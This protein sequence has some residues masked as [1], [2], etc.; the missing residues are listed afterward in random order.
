MT[1]TQEQQILLS[2]NDVLSGHKH[3]SEHPGNQFLDHLVDLYCE[4]Y[5]KTVLQNRFQITN[6]VI[7]QIREHGGRFLKIVHDDRLE[8]LDERPIAGKVTKLLRQRG[9]EVRKLREQQQKGSSG[10][11]GEYSLHKRSRED[12]DYADDSDDDDDIVPRHSTPKTSASNKSNTTDKFGFALSPR[13]S[14][15]MRINYLAADS[16]RS[17]TGIWG[18]GDTTT[19]NSNHHRGTNAATYDYDSDD[20]SFDDGGNSIWQSFERSSDR[21][22]DDTSWNENYHHLRDFYSKQGHT[23]VSIDWDG[24][25][26][27]AEWA[28]QQR[29]LFREIQSGY[30]IPTMREENRWTQLQ[31]V[32]FPLNYEKWHWE[33]KY[34]Q[35]KEVLKGEKYDA[36]KTIVLPKDIQTWLDHQR[37]LMKD[38]GSVMSSRR[39]EYDR[40]ERLKCLGVE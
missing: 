4:E 20:N 8:M 28:A 33:R 18:Q 24:N 39:M 40:K 36:E 7:R 11:G 38:D 2:D 26:A 10:G 15:H 22:E 1:S 37:L 9:L 35:L 12:D 6:R 25:T 21:I 31:M 32:N 30:R 27:L 34:R 3:S 19:T 23:G 5:L 14:A 17:P 16:S 29:Q 13:S